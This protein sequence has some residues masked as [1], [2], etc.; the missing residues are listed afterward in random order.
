[1]NI[2]KRADE[3][4]N[5]V[6]VLTGVKTNKSRTYIQVAMRRCI[7]YQLHLDGLTEGS[8][9]ELVGCD[10]STAHYHISAMRN[11]MREPMIGCFEYKLFNNLHKLV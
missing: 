10:H 3:I 4:R 7:I 2:T 9:G 5:V 11:I 6:E 8:I 1:M